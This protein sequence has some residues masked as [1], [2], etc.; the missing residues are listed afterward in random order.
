VVRRLTAK[1]FTV[2]GWRDWF[3]DCIQ[4]FR[5]HPYPTAGH[6][7]EIDLQE[8]REFG[9]EMAEL[10]KRISAGE[11][12]LIPPI[13]EWNLHPQMIN[14]LEFYMSHGLRDHL[15]IKYDKEKCAYPKCTL[16]MDNCMMEY[17]DLS[18]E[19]RNFGD[20]GTECSMWMGCTFCELICPTGAIYCDQFENLES[21]GKMMASMRGL[22]AMTEYNLFEREIDKLEAE[23]KFRRLLPREEIGWN[24]PYIVSHPNRPRFKIPKDDDSE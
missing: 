10:S 6:P 15:P 5:A 13:P 18:A 12:D 14:A 9:K 8:A 17:I 20:K 2:I 23:G 3:G 24:T 22:V 7:D 19:P 4:Q 16:C 21:M 1:G 11:K